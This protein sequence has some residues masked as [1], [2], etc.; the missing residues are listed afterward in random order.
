[1]GDGDMH[2]ACGNPL[3]FTTAYGVLQSTH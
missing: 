1:L 2:V 3:I